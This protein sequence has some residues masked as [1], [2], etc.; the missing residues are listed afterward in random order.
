M[1]LLLLPNLQKFP[2][3]YW[4]RQAMFLIFMYFNLVYNSNRLFTFVF[5]IVLGICSQFLD[6]LLESST[7]LHSLHILVKY[8]LGTWSNILTHFCIAFWTKQASF[9]CNITSLNCGMVCIHIR[10]VF[11][12]LVA[13][14]F[15]TR[16]LR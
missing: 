14:Y 9:G 6:F 4:I 8:I 1:R 3:S 13:G 12:V 15:L 5:L 16:F 2:N 10:T 7:D 11:R